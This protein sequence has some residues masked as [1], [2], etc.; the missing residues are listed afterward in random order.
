MSASPPTSAGTD[1]MFC[2]LY[3]KLRE[4][5][6]FEL[7]QSSDRT[8]DTTA[9]VHETYLKLSRDPRFSGISRLHMLRLAAKAMRQIVIDRARRR[10]AQKR[11][12]EFVLTTLGEGP[13]ETFDEVT[14]LALEHAL[15]ELG[16]TDARLAEVVE[17]RFFGGLSAE[18]TAQ[19][20]QVTERT[21][22]RDWRKAR[23]FLFA[24]LDRDPAR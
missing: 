23:A 24:A 2:A 20:L 15:M 19:I 22:V 1:V 4:R 17:L 10:G 6:H 5:A 7:L 21:V 13:A 11:G 16:A 12:A 8:L 14:V 9:L 3:E 18:D